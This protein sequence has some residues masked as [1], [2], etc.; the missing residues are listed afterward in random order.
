MVS[1]LAFLGLL[2]AYLVL[3]A[4]FIEATRR[5]KR[6][7]KLMTDVTDLNKELIASLEQAH[8]MNGRMRKLFMSTGER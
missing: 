1:T 3:L 8:D 6:L 7:I 5:N 2:A 4:G